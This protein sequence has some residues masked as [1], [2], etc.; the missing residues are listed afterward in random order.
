M[1]GC[2]NYFGFKTKGYWK[3]NASSL[4][5]AFNPDESAGE[6]YAYT[7]VNNSKV[8]VEDHNNWLADPY[9]YGCPVCKE[10]IYLGLTTR[11]SN[12]DD[13]YQNLIYI[14]PDK[15]I[16]EEEVSI[17]F[18]A[19]RRITLEGKVW[20]DKQ[21]GDKPVNEPNS[22]YNYE[23][24]EE[25]EPFSDIEVILKKVGDDTPVKT[26]KT[27][28]DGK[29]I[30]EDVI[31]DG[32]TEYYIEFRYDGIN[33]EAVTANQGSEDID[34][35]AKEVDR[36]T[37]NKKF[38]T[39]TKGTAT[40]G[41]KSID[42]SY[43]RNG[44]DAKLKTRDSEGVLTDFAMTAKTVAEAYKE[45]T[46]NIDLG[47]VE[48]VV[49]L[50]ATTQ[51]E[52]AI[53]FINNNSKVYEYNV[54][55]GD[56]TNKTIKL[57]DETATYNLYLY[58]S[59]YNYRIMDY[60]GLKTL[61][62]A[63]GTDSSLL[64][65]SIDEIL[66]EYKNNQ[67]ELNI[68]LEDK[69]ALNILLKYQVL[70]NNESATTATVNNI[71][72]YYEKGLFNDEIILI[73]KE[74]EYGNKIPIEDCT[75]EEGKFTDSSDRKYNRI[76][77]P[78]KSELTESDN[79]D[80]IY[81]E[82]LI[83]KDDYG[84]AK[85]GD[86][87]NWVE[88]TSYS[89]DK[90]CIDIDSAPDNIEEYREEDD[91]D[92]A[93]VV[94]IKN[95]I[96]ERTISGY[97]FEDEKEG[98]TNSAGN[99]LY[100][101][102]ENKVNDV[103][104]QLIEVKDITIGGTAKRL[105]YIWQETRSGSGKVKYITTNGTSIEEYSVDVQE[106]GYLFKGFI[107]GNYI[108]RFIYGD[109]TYFDFDVSTD[110]GKANIVKYNGQ[111]YKSAIDPNYQDKE[112]DE[113]KYDTNASMA[114]D[115]E[116]RRIEEMANVAGV[117]NPQDL[118]FN[119]NDRN[120]KTKLEKTWM[121]AE[122]SDIKIPIT[123]DNTGVISENKVSKSINFGLVK[124]PEVS[125]ELE[126]HIT[127]LT[128]NG[129][130]GNLV[131]TS[132]TVDDIKKAYDSDYKVN[133]NGG[134]LS[135]I[136][137]T[138]KEPEKT[139]TNKNTIGIWKVETELA[140]VQGNYM[141]ITYTYT[142]KLSGDLSYIGEGLLDKNLKEDT[143]IDDIKSDINYYK[144]KYI[145]QVYYTGVVDNTIDKLDRVEDIKIEDYLVGLDLN[146]GD[147]ETKGNAEK[148]I[149]MDTDPVKS[150]TENVQII[151]SVLDVDND[152]KSEV[153]SG[154]NYQ[155]ELT[156][157]KK[158]DISGGKDLEYRS[159]VAQLIGLENTNTFTTKAGLTL[160][161]T[162]GN[163]EYVQ[164]YSPVTYTTDVAPESDE[165]IAETVLITVDTGGTVADSNKEQKLN[166]VIAVVAGLAVV[167]TGIV[168]IKKFVI[169]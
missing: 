72:Y 95:Q 112:Y 82:F 54:A 39:I 6:E 10:K 126:K 42:L 56:D 8:Y 106:G 132:I 139:N 77:I 93:G 104:V 58:K 21:Y 123:Q 109:G 168:L 127:N 79:Q 116:M 68:I 14:N 46:K 48:R 40:G 29:Y 167:A 166:L 125:I 83:N 105:E 2:D 25:D 110:E 41:D 102:G 113:N 28:A 90:G 20:L 114:R 19:V 55:S 115:N 69:E 119:I 147:F 129:D 128:I 103:I 134:E 81:I 88:I 155:K 53:V 11:A 149:L 38:T 130:E 87:E 85:M 76:N 152:G 92:N 71:A 141:Y 9:N 44:T 65:N 108:V 161:S 7:I 137:V 80:V 13:I 98:T 52:S 136:T 43:E 26:T 158:I 63:N 24:N 96:S 122:T 121:C 47:L 86:V 64:K 74:D 120:I 159:Y 12:D 133:K 144:G 157:T 57:E 78:V 160:N 162:L 143:D 17:E 50:S 107:P 100:E 165:F 111:D 75:F 45:D 61:S 30:F 70:I 62:D 15:E 27:D 59:D 140:N 67:G 37:F 156:V 34:S 148:G 118:I 151:Q 60:A 146:S 23:P 164:S 89:A 22:L 124:R 49:D 97:V 16:I 35:D 99:G 94:S 5:E 153:Y 66:E 1:S 142:V 51:I 32:K 145:G 33:Y 31:A 101:D 154:A 150:D 36:D 138:N 131:E 135:S 169:K 4:T 73:Y 91:S 117:T 84:N 163:L 3:D 18:L